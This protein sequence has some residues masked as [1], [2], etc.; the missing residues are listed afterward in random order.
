MEAKP[1]DGNIQPA[2]FRNTRILTDSICPKTSRV[3]RERESERE[4]G[5]RVSDGLS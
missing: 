1:E 2:G 5:G 4:R 3:H